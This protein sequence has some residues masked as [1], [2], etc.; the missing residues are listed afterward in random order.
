M[1]SA[2]S[3]VVGAALPPARV[4]ALAAS[5][6]PPRVLELQRVVVLMMPRA[7]A[8][9][10]VVALMMPALVL[11]LAVAS[12]RALV[13]PLAFAPARALLQG[14]SYV[15]TAGSR[16]RCSDLLYDCEI[17]LCRRG[18]IIVRPRSGPI[19]SA[20]GCKVLASRNTLAS[21]LF[22]NKTCVNAAKEAT[23]TRVDK[24]SIETMASTRRK[25]ACST[26]QLNSGHS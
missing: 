2:A 6:W 19:A 23:N 20:P 7:L 21:W 5:L 13:L 12:T 1:A 4:Q 24:L 26:P 14:P 16:H 18:A 9:V 15:C 11:P 3:A 10:L 8:R 25:N 22:C 17:D